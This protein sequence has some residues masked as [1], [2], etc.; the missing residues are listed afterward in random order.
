MQSDM[1]EDLIN[2]FNKQDIRKFMTIIIIM[3]RCGALVES[4]PF[5]WRVA[6]SNPTLAAPQGPWANP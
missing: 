3:R 2:L 1:T 6:G 5:D 4:K